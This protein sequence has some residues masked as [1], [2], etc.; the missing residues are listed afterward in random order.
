MN[1]EDSSVATPKGSDQPSNLNPRTDYSEVGRCLGCG[2]MLK[3]L[4]KP[5]CP[6]CGRAFD[7]YDAASMKLPGLRKSHMLWPR[8]FGRLMID[9]SLVAGVLTLYASEGSEIALILAPLVWLVVP[10]SV[11][12]RRRHRAEILST[13]DEPSWQLTVKIIFGV[14]VS[15]TFLILFQYHSCPHGTTIGIGPVGLC[16]STNGGPCHNDGCNGGDQLFGNW[17]CTRFTTWGLGQPF[18][19]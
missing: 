4:P 2:Y 14:T 12:L 16:Y 11:W 3:S 18:N 17:Y 5:R 13:L 1:A 8:T 9:I 15:L 10:I 6:E 19:R 7:R